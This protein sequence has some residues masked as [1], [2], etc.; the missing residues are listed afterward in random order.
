MDLQSTFTSLFLLEFPM[1]RQMQTFGLPRAHPELS[2]LEP[3]EDSPWA[4]T[5]W[6][7]LTEIPHYQS[8]PP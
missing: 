6:F 5:D 3:H 7:I 2:L 8:G 4:L 1:M